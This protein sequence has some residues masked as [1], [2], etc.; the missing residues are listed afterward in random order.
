MT[1]QETKD[2]RIIYQAGGVVV[3]YSTTTQELN[4]KAPDKPT[5]GYI[6][7][8]I[9]GMQKTLWDMQMLPTP[10]ETEELLVSCISDAINERNGMPVGLQALPVDLPEGLQALHP[11]EAAR[12]E[13]LDTHVDWEWPGEEIKRMGA[14]IPVR[15][16]A[17]LLGYSGHLT[18]EAV[19]A[20]L[21][22]KF[23][24]KKYTAF[25]QF[26]VRQFV[27]RDMGPMTVVFVEFGRTP[28]VMTAGSLAV[29]GV[30]PVIARFNLRKKGEI[31]QLLEGTLGVEHVD[32]KE[33]KSSLYEMVKSC[34][35]EDDLWRLVKKPAEAMGLLMMWKKIHKRTRF[36]PLDG[37]ELFG[38]QQE[39]KA[40]MFSPGNKR[41]IQWRYD[42]IGGIGKSD[43]QRHMYAVGGNDVLILPQLSAVYHMSQVIMGQREKGWTGR[44]LI[45]NLVRSADGKEIYETLEQLAD[46]LMLSLKYEGGLVEWAPEHIVVYANWLPEIYGRLSADRWRIKTVEDPT[47]DAGIEGRGARVTLRTMGLQE[48]AAVP[49]SRLKIRQ[50]DGSYKMRSAPQQIAPTDFAAAMGMVPSAGSGGGH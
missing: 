14:I 30:D 45:I 27:R 16:G 22:V 49:R 50:K 18:K 39:E 34:Q 3:R 9:E 21:A 15:C 8:A 37:K 43:F 35:S 7:A 26:E 10:A 17:I 44:L 46:G 24:T 41:H 31:T 11:G 29:N 5:A 23:L 38:W 47:P 20:A 40:F 19:H 6:Q 13:A 33:G 42:K 25:L 12:V 48:A 36:D 1:Q 28:K 2:T 32:V 4:I